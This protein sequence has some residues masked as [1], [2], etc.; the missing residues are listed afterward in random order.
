MYYRHVLEV[1]I[2]QQTIQ[3]DFH[4]AVCRLALAGSV[5]RRYHWRMFRRGISRVQALRIISLL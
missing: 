1:Q 2:C 5:T 3:N 4:F